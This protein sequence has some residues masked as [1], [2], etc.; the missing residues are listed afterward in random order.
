M[1]SVMDLI[2]QVAEI[3]S[4]SSLE[5]RLHPWIYLQLA[6]LPGVTVERIPEHNLLISVPGDSRLAPIALA[7]HLDKIDHWGTS[8]ERLPWRQEPD[9]LV[10]Q[11]DDAVG[12]GICL[13]L[14]RWGAGAVGL[15][16]LFVLLSEME[17][18]YGLTHHPERLVA[19]GTG[20]QCGQGAVRLSRHL[21]ETGRMPGL[22]VTIDTTPL[23]QGKPGVAL[24]AAPW[25]EEPFSP[26][27]GL[28]RGTAE[29]CELLQSLD[30][31]LRIANNGNDYATYGLEFNRNSLCAIPS[32]ALEPA[33]SPYHCAGESVFL[34]DI[35]RVERLTQGLVA[36]W[37]R[38]GHWRL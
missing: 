18:S 36:S 26:G 29:V 13:A 25:E 21:K 7:A 22:V 1:S 34:Q 2:R 10:G 35:E 16:P 15:P 4:F 23:F 24:Y 33:I 8:P 12:V 5:D 9:R 37:T 38:T 32:I 11:M 3:P 20:R 17:E 28:L 27:A 19:G 30:G 6:S 31:G 14:A